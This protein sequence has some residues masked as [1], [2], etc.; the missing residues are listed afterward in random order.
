MLLCGDTLTM[1][2][3]NPGPVPTHTVILVTDTNDRDKEV[4]GEYKLLN[5]NIKKYQR[6]AKD[7]S[8]NRMQV[9]LKI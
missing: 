5:Y 7:I 2:S 4:T 9:N 6:L 8:E 1:L 3:W